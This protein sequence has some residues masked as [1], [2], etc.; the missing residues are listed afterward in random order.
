M[1]DRLSIDF[2]IDRSFVFRQ[3]W[4]DEFIVDV[5]RALRFWV[6]QV[7]DERDFRLVVQGQEE[8]K[9]IREAF[10]HGKRGQDEPIDA[11]SAELFGRL[12]V[13]FERLW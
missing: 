6:P 7:H 11:P 4:S 3:R 2:S 10:K 13:H 5:Q 1:F 12:F 9:G 8:Q